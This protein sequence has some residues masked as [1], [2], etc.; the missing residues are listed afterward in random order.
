LIWGG[1]PCQRSISELIFC[2][3]LYLWTWCTYL[4]LSMT[5]CVLHA[6]SLSFVLYYHHVY[7]RGRSSETVISWPAFSHKKFSSYFYVVLL[8]VVKPKNSQKPWLLTLFYA[9]QDLSIMSCTYLIVPSW[10][11]WACIRFLKETISLVK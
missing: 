11:F 7:E 3:M 6:L 8:V 4:C 10:D 5:Y 1:L 2:G 9:F